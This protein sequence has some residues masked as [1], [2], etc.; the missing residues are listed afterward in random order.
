MRRGFL[1]AGGAGLV[2]L[3]LYPL[4]GSGYGVRFML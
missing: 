2:A 1:V 4:V 3:A